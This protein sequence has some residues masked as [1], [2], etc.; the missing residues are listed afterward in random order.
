VNAADCFKVL[1]PTS[2]KFA[3][4]AI[5]VLSNGSTSRCAGVTMDSNDFF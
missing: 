1:K 4:L 5:L 2:L 3:R